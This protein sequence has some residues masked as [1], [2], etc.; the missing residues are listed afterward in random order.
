MATTLVALLPP[1]GNRAHSGRN[2][3]N[4]PQTSTTSQGTHPRFY[5]MS[6]RPT[7]EA[8]DVV[9]TG[10][11]T[12]CTLDDYALMDSKSTFS[13]VTPYFALNFGIKPEQL[14]EPFS[15][16]TP[17]EDFVIASCIY[18]GCVIIIQD[19]ETTTDLIELEIVDFDVI[20]GM[21]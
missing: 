2:A 12:I 17:V 14:L 10:I 4:V 18:R 9:I 19:R 20:M 16:S 15:V 6:T 11:L 8:S 5:A 21:D 13:Y 1:R 3:G 7:A